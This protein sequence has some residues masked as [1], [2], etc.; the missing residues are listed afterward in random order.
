MA[1]AVVV[2]DFQEPRQRLMS[3]FLTDS[4]IENAQVTTLHEAREALLSHPRVLIV[5]SS[6]ATTEIASII[7]QFRKMDGGELRIIVLHGGGHQGA[8]AL[9]DADICIHDV[10]DPDNLVEAVRAAL[11]GDVPATEPHDAAEAVTKD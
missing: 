8:A 10:D 6:A 7:Q 5:N 9:V 11:E 2:F 3:W 1:A 4:G